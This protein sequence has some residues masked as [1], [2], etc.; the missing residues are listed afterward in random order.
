[1]LHDVLEIAHVE[2]LPMTRPKNEEIMA[3]LSVKDPFTEMRFL[4]YIDPDYL[5][6]KTSELRLECFK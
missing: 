4:M 2:T 1:M 3:T 5:A 6:L